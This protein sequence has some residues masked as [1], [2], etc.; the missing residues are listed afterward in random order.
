MAYLQNLSTL[1]PQTHS[2]L[3]VQNNGNLTFTNK[4]MEWGLGF[5]THSNGSAYGD[6]DNDGD[7]D[8]VLNNVNMP[9]LVFENKASQLLPENK[10]IT[11]FQLHGEGGNSFALGTKITVKVKNQKIYQE[12]SPMRGFM[13]S[14]ENR[15]T[16][17]LGE[18]SIADSVL[19][20][21]P[22]GKV[23]TLTKIK[24]NQI[25]QLNQK[26]ACQCYAAVLEKL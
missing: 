20:E 23:T 22:D 24:T 9:S 4:G 6:L 12:L 2:E 14:V 15:I 18:N 16:I 11:L 7:L 17:G 26:D 1:F 10:S 21:W 19:V 25:I 13:S 8:L 5:P 3:C